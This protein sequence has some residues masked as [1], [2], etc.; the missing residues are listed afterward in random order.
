[1]KSI[2]LFLCATLSIAYGQ[3]LDGRFVVPVDHFRPQ[4]GRTAPFVDNFNS[5]S[6]N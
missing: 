6:E 5:F 3:L 1:M 4:D 2:L